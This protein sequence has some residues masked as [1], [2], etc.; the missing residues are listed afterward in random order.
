[1]K[2]CNT[3]KIATVPD[4]PMLNRLIPN[5]FHLPAKDKLVEKHKMSAKPRKKAPPYITSLLSS[6]NPKYNKAID[7]RKIKLVTIKST[8]MR[9]I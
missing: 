2:I 1:M 9:L 8:L 4:C 5:S 6:L 7:P 3:D